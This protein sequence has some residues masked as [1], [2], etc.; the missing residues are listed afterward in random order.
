[1]YFFAHFVIIRTK[2]GLVISLKRFLTIFSILC[3]VF[4]LAVLA[5][6]FVLRFTDILSAKYT[7]MPYKKRYFRQN[8]SKTL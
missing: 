3:A 7:W 2:K 5:A 1:M 6:G 8:I 4:V